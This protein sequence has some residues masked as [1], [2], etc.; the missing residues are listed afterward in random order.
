MAFTTYGLR[1]GVRTNTPAVL[2]QLPAVFPPGWQPDEAPEDDRLY[3]LVVGGR[4]P[5]PSVRR[6]NIVYADAGRVGRS[7]DLDEVLSSLE[8]DLR[9]YVA[10]RARRRLFVHAGVVGWQGKAI[11][12]PGAS[13][14]GK[15]SLVAALVRGGATYYS[16]D[17]AVFDRRGRVHPFA[18]PLSIREGT[19]GKTRRW[20]PDALGG[21][22]GVAPLP[23]GLVVVTT[24]RAGA[25]W[26][27]R[28]LSPGRAILELL[29]HTVPARR[30]PR[31]AIATLRN[32]VATAPVLKGRRG[33]TEP[34]RDWLLNRWRTEERHD[35]HS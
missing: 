24:Y 17:Y 1:I 25:A 11:V 21:S 19:N 3:S 18:T 20:S 34:M 7:M 9:I 4:G 2:D 33:E 12:I 8:G 10:E 13:L 6:Y 15:S 30:R 31:S 5:R 27:G 22:P 32:V 35:A 23:V 28:R 16:D 14:S 29:R 26:R